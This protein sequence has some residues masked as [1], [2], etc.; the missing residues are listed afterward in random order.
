M[1]KKYIVIGFDI[2]NTFWL[3][4][5]K[6]QALDEA[7]VVFPTPPVPQNIS[8]FVIWLIVTLLSLEFHAITHIFVQCEIESNN[9]YEV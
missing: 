4:W 1:R 5:D 9:D 2:N 6:Y 8:I 7:S 3:F